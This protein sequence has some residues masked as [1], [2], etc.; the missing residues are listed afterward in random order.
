MVP[1]TN[2]TKTM[3][4]KILFLLAAIVMFGCGDDKGY[5]INIQ[6]EEMAGANMVLKQNV[7]G[8]LISLDS[9][10]LDE[11]GAGVISGAA[12][13]PELVF[14]GE[15]GKR[16]SLAIFLDNY[17]YTISGTLEDVNIVADGGPQ[18]EYNSYKEG[19]VPFQEKQKAITDKYYAAQSAEVSEDSINA[20]LQNYYAVND[21]K[22]SYDSIYI[23]QNSTSPVAVYLLRGLYHQF[24]ATELEAWLARLDESLHNTS[25]YTFMA[26][27]Q[28]KMKN[29]MVGN[30]YTELELPGV[31]GEL[32]K[33]SDI[34]GNG[35][36]LI[37]F[38][39]AWCGPCRVAN[40]GIVELYKE[41]HEQGFDIV[42]VSL[43]RTK[44]EWLQ[45]IEDDGLTWHHMS[46]LNFWQSEA[47]KKY[48]VS[49]IPHTVLLDGEGVIIGKNLSKKELR[50]KLVEL[51]GT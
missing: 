47:A 37:D 29:V 42:G 19:I 30:Q 15:S 46:D 39:A 21:E 45:A 22:K 10:I 14:L 7:S 16:E 28:Q 41:F 49:S 35:I 24:D 18:V 6:L 12:T 33:L 5:T 8:E 13:A 4:K 43:D 50:E 2:Q 25:Y 48:A 32:V 38:W 23:I 11:N 27:H 17:N 40:P 34:A 1:S 36:L 3:M 20:I 44:E 51:L 31:D 26:D 9:V